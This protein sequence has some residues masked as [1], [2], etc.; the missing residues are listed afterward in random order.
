MSSDQS[1]GQELEQRLQHGLRAVREAMAGNVGTT[2]MLEGVGRDGVYNKP[3]VFVHGELMTMLLATGRVYRYNQDVVIEFRGEGARL[4]TLREGN[5]VCGNAQG[6]L[7][8]IVNCRSET[9]QSAVEFPVPLRVIQTVLCNDELIGRLPEILTYAKRPMFDSLYRYYGPGWHPEVGFLIHCPEFEPVEPPSQADGGDDASHWP[10]HLGVVLQ[11]FPFS[12]DADRINAL[13]VLL[14]GVLANAFVEAGKPLIVLDGNQPGVGKTLFGLILGR[15]LDDT[16]VTLIPYKEDEEE[17]EKKVC[18]NLRERS[19]SVLLFDNARGSGGEIRSVF[20]EANCLASFVRLRVLGTS[21]IHTQPNYM[22]WVITA[23]HTRLNSDLM[24]RACPIRLHVD[25][26][27]KTWYAGRQK[28]LEFIR[29][30]RLQLLGELYGLIMVWAAQGCSPGQYS[31][32]L[33]TWACAIGGILEANGFAGFLSNLE[34]ATSEFNV[35]V[36]ELQSLLQ[37]LFRLEYSLNRSLFQ[38]VSNGVASPPVGVPGLK[39]SDWVSYFNLA[40]VYQRRLR[41]ASS[42]RGRSVIVGMFL[43]RFVGRQF[44]VESGFSGP[45]TAGGYATL[46]LRLRNR[47]GGKHYYIEVLP[48]QDGEN[49]GPVVP[50]AAPTGPPSLPVTFAA[51]QGQGEP[52]VAESNAGQGGSL[53]S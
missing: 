13:G 11:H 8:N 50:P 6:M 45:S 48:D 24:D 5:R 17:L 1:R 16:D 22:I 32:R 7:S 41:E 42:D 43:S 30:N 26:D 35:D 21:D 40:N 2:A 29:E 20:I 31:H 18:A 14:T 51:A 28:I 33:G 15:L 44:R 39:P 37:Y 34:E 46:I 9:T 4:V 3:M 12:S 10:H 47:H 49:P 38:R 27:A 53:L 23:N 19:S 25:G 36:D 52:R